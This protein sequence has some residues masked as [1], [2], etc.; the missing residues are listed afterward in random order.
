MLRVRI[1]VEATL[2]RPRRDAVSLTLKVRTGDAWGASV[3]QWGSGG[4]LLD[5][6]AMRAISA[7]SLGQ[8]P[9]RLL[10]PTI[11]SIQVV[12]ENVARLRSR[13]LP[14]R[15]DLDR[16]KGTISELSLRS[17]LNVDK[18]DKCPTLL[19]VCR[20]PMM[21]HHLLFAHFAGIEVLLHRHGTLVVFVVQLARICS[22]VVLVGYL[23]KVN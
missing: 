10:G 3:V 23:A 21:V 22:V 17:R 20:L 1:V 13:R 7:Y 9:S 12:L 8:R 6:L 5:V 14:D 18:L 19:M 4:F 2:R 15:E 16:S 11:V